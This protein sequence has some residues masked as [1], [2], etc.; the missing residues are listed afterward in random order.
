[1]LANPIA[2][3]FCIEFVA[4]YMCIKY[5]VNDCLKAKITAIVSYDVELE[6][7]L[8]GLATQIFEQNYSVCDFWRAGNAMR[9]ET[10]NC[11]SIKKLRSQSHCD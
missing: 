6:V 10:D 7:R 8:S 9:T 2:V 3:P 4:S 5:A 1:M 11:A